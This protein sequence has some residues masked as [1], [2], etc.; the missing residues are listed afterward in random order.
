MAL[1]ILDKVAVSARK[2]PRDID[3]KLHPVIAGKLKLSPDEIDY[4]ILGKSIDS[5]RSEA[6]FIYRLAVSSE[7]KLELPELSQEQM[8]AL[9]KAELPLPEKSALRHPI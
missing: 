6:M 5:R 4:H 1:Y 3:E 2:A 7:K 9:G 8:A